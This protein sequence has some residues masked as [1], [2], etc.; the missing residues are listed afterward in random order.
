MR[1]FGVDAFEILKRCHIYIF[2]QLDGYLSLKELTSHIAKVAKKIEYYIITIMP[3]WFKN[4][5][6]LFGGDK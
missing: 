6:C 4:L 1:T 5:S 3:N 2:L